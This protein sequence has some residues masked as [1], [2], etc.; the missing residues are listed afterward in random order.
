MVMNLKRILRHLLS[1]PF[2][3]RGCFNPKLLKALSEEVKESESKHQG[4]LKIIVECALD[5]LNLV[6]GQ[7]AR[8]RAIELFSK[9]RIWDTEE[10][11]GILLYV[12][13]SD[14]QFEIIADR[15]IAS[16]VTEPYWENLSSKIEEYFRR[17]SFFEGMKYGLHELTKLMSEHFPH[18]TG[19]PNQISDNVILL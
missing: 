17:E 10:N 3:M 15:G 19:A 4:E 13:W 11:C 9:H 12:L 1:T 14:R 18:K 7:T 5:F 2:K 6:M 16:R 8:E